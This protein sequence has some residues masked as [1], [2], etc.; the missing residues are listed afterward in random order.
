MSIL[1]SI[2]HGDDDADKATVGFV[3]ASAAAASAQETTVF[4][5]SN[6]A[7]LA[8]KGEAGKIH[9]EGFAPL[10]DLMEGFLEA[11]GSLLVCS[12]CAKKRGIGEDDVVDGAQIVGG[13]TVVE[14]MA[15][16]AATLT[17]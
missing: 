8:K 10:A 5:S 1:I 2:T 14:I 17:Y 13:G 7:W 3:V 16:G 15:R 9:E 11:G 4:L 12:P 6:G